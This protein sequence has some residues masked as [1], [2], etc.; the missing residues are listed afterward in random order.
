MPRQPAAI[1]GGG[2]NMA[3]S[4]PFAIRSSAPSPPSEVPLLYIRCS[5]S[6]PANPSGTPRVP[7]HYCNYC[8]YCTRGCFAF[9]L[10]CMILSTRFF[11]G[12]VFRSGAR[13]SASEQ[14]F[15]KSRR[16]VGGSTEPKCATKLEGMQ[17]GGI[18]DEP[19]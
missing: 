17:T 1:L 14:I 9:V 3:L 12:V 8:N 11:F 7:S 5:V 13:E 19:L 2:G 10:L 4:T 15:D 6:E 18:G 16:A